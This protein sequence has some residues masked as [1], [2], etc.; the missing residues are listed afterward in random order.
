MVRINPA[1]RTLFHLDAVAGFTEQ[2]IEERAALTWPRDAEGVPL[3]YDEVPPVRVLRGELL[4]GTNSDEVLVRLPDG[5]DARVL[6]TG[7]PLRDTDGAMT[8]AVVTYQDITEQ[9]RA[10]MT[11]RFQSSLLDRTHDAIFV[12]E[13]G[14]PIIYWNRG[15]E[16]LYGYQASEALGQVSHRLLR[17]VHPLPSPQAFEAMLLRDGEWTGELTHTTR[18]GRMVEVLSRHQMLREPDGHVYVLE[19]SHDI[20]TRKRL[21]EQREELLSLV[22]H[23]LGSPLTTMKA[24]TQVMQRQVAAGKSLPAEAFDVVSQEIGRMER[25]IADLRVSECLEA[26]HFTLVLEPCDLLV[27]C[28][29]TVEALQISTGREVRLV[30]PETSV[31]AMIDRD[32]IGQVLANLLSNALKYSLLD[33]PVELTLTIKE[34]FDD[35]SGDGTPVAQRAVRIA[36]RDRGVGIPPEAQPHL[37]ERYYR[38]PG[39]EAQH[40]GGGARHGLGLGLYIARELVERH[41]GRIGVESAVGKGS[42]F[43]FTIPL[44]RSEG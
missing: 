29:N 17:T 40:S 31:V 7:A 26:G 19:T 30:L 25:L 21:E 37:F 28:R 9:R 34:R 22:V 43:W 41:G 4:R 16:L 15:A 10:E 33:Q 2:T 6:V 18:D 14:G 3:P 5:H 27:L 12:W 42:T 32:R 39:I 38:V 20:T 35:P 36:V 13:A 1:A 24:R 11:I 44:A 8:G 23:D